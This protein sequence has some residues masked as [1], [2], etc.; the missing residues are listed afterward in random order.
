MGFLMGAAGTVL[1]GGMACLAGALAFAAQ[2]GS[3]R[4]QVWP[5]Y[6]RMGLVP[7]EE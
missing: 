6:K 3:F 7:P 5:I 2:L 4:Q 1:L